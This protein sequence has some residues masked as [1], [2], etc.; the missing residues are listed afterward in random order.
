MPCEDCI[1]ADK[2]KIYQSLR[3]AAK[4][5]RSWADV[6]EDTIPCRR[7]WGCDQGGTYEVPYRGE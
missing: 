3:E 1:G 2:C 5:G 4:Q 6:V 7:E